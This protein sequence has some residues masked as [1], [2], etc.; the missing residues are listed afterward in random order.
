MAAPSVVPDDPGIGRLGRSISQSF[1][2]LPASKLNSTLLMVL[3][4]AEGDAAEV[5]LGSLQRLI[6]ARAVDAREDFD[7]SVIRPAFSLP[8]AEIIAVVDFDLDNPFYVLDA[9]ESGHDQPEGKP[10]SFGSFSP[11]IR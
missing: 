5:L 4:P 11:F 1:H 9:V 10:C 3:R 7:R 6:V 2:V 8:V